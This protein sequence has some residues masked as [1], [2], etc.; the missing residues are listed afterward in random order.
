MKVV[1]NE[2]GNGNGNGEKANKVIKRDIWIEMAR[3]KN[4]R[5]IMCNMAETFAMADMTRFAD[6]GLSLIRKRLMVTLSAEEVLPV[7]REF[8]EKLI[9]MEGTIK[10]LCE[11]ANV[12]KYSTPKTVKTVRDMLSGKNI[13]DESASD[14]DQKESKTGKKAA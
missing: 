9:D 7:L 12:S 5:V 11:L 1:K 3:E 14:E 13:A 2:K 6:L 10:Q 4:A 8:Q